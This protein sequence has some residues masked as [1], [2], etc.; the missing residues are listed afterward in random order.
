MTGAEP[1]EKVAHLIEDGNQGR[2]KK[3]ESE[4]ASKVQSATPTSA[5]G[6][7]VFRKKKLHLKNTTDGNNV[8]RFAFGKGFSFVA[9]DSPA[10][11]GI[12]IILIHQNLQ[13]YLIGTFI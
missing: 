6:N 13:T 9:E 8:T 12:S 2:R 10:L 11:N 3:R 7:F 4:E 1:L 5:H